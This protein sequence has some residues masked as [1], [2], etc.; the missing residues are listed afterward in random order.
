MAII[1]AYPVGT[2]ASGDYLVGSDI[3]TAGTQINPTKNF[4]ISE[5]VDTGLGYVAYTS[6][7]TQAGVV[8]PTEV[9][10]KN[11]TVATMTW[12]YTGPGIYTCTASAP[13]FTAAKT[14]VFINQGEYVSA[15][16]SLRWFHTNTSVIT[17]NTG[18][19]NGRITNGAF[20]IRIYT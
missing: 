19:S 6:I 11:G 3:T 10:L 20:E 14:I 7:L 4:V 15:P 13:V 12:G 17:L 5:V 2:P 16:S 18:G 8:A 1:S 9:L